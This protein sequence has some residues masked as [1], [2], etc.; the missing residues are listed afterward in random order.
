MTATAVPTMED[1][2]NNLDTIRIVQD[3]MARGKEAAEKYHGGF[4]ISM[5][6]PIRQ[7]DM[8]RA[9]RNGVRDA[10]CM[11]IIKASKMRVFQLND[12]DW[13]MAES[14][15]QAVELYM[16]ETGLSRSEAYDE[17]VACEVPL[18]ALASM[19]LLEDGKDAG[20]TF[21]HGLADMIETN[22]PPMWFASTEF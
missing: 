7:E 8:N 3:A 16:Q 5:E 18:K 13:Y 6:P 9:I 2:L 14:M 20:E 12:C 21:L 11:A 19:P 17:S 15:E 4:W 22:H 10:H 1:L